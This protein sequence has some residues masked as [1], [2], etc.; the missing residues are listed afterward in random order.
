MTG[1]TT[2]HLTRLWRSLSLPKLKNNT[3][4]SIRSALP[5]TT[6]IWIQSE[7]IDAG[8][9]ELM[10]VLKDPMAAKL[11]EHAVDMVMTHETDKMTAMGRMET[12][13]SLAL[14]SADATVTL[15]TTEQGMNQ[16]AS[17]GVQADAQDNDFVFPTR[18]VD[19][20]DGV[21]HV[22][23]NKESTELPGVY[24]KVTVP[25][26][27][28]LIC[29]IEGK[30]GSISIS[31][32]I[33]GDVKLST[34][35]GDICVTKLR[36]HHVELSTGSIDNVIHAKGLLEARSLKIQTKGRVRAK[37]IHGRSV[38]INVQNDDSSQVCVRPQYLEEDDGDEG[39]L[40]D[41][42]ALYVTG[43]GDAVINVSDPC[44]PARRA[45]RIKSHHGPVQVNTSNLHKPYEM[46][47][48]LAD[49]NYYPLVEVGGVNGN[50]EISIQKTSAEAITAGWTSC[51]CHFDSITPQSVSLV[52]VDRGDVSLMID[53]KLEADLR[54]LSMS[55][56][57][58]LI[59]SGALLAE[60]ENTEII[61][62]VLKNMPIGNDADKLDKRIMIETKAFTIRG[63]ALSSDTIEYV[64]GWV[65]N[66]SGEPDSRFEQK[67]GGKI[68]LNSAR[69]QALKGFGKSV[70]GG[71]AGSSPM[72]PL[73]AVA[74][75]GRVVLE[76]ISWIGS[77]ARN[78]GVEEE[79]M[80]LGRQASR[81][82][83]PI[84]VADE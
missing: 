26:K 63:N 68:D 2:R 51:S 29:E 76:S 3:T 71:E 45:V 53:R 27:V 16:E 4:L 39:S 73:I 84:V 42:G 6:H 22:S 49:K 9:V 12:H 57:E 74:S 1:P 24:V 48:R 55:S 18:R 37:Q 80:T 19:Y 20:R 7:W 82:G 47:A 11:K 5:Q 81:K 77:I 21:A 31:S 75:T 46:N 69:E 79:R 83:R 65:E 59:E 35:D 25:E 34:V 14:M 64:D 56:N 36:G 23:Q 54:L 50:C 17:N 67:Q 62:N 15:D 66:K 28:N 30:G 43:E 60:E 58:C 41:I 78:Y 13:V 32:K 38:Q 40:V 44:R 8:L 33:E 72:R 70:N 10:H 52:T 61:A